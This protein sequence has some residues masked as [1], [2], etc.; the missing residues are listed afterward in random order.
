M[1]WKGRCTYRH[2]SRWHWRWCQ[3]AL[4]QNPDTDH[5]IPGSILGEFKTIQQF[6]IFRQRFIGMKWDYVELP[7]RMVVLGTASPG[8]HEAMT[9][10][11]AVSKMKVKQ[12]NVSTYPLLVRKSER[13]LNASSS[14]SEA[15]LNTTAY[16]SLAELSLIC[17]RYFA[18]L[19]MGTRPSIRRWSAGNSVFH[20][21]ESGS[22]GVPPI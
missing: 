6:K 13:A 7:S 20:N 10:R 9:P 14:A 4:V 17:R 3:F 12:S 16:S 8:E 19:S 21:N 11:D 18:E 5:I 1:Q 15:G 22:N 2:R